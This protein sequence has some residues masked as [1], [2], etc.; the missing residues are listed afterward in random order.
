MHRLP[1]MSGDAPYRCAIDPR[2]VAASEEQMNAAV[3]RVVDEFIQLLRFG[4]EGVL[5]IVLA[6]LPELATARLSEDDPDFERR[7]VLQT[8]V[9]HRLIDAAEP[10]LR[11]SL[12]IA[13][14]EV[15]QRG[16]WLEGIVSR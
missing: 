6:A 13:L 15:I 3:E 12:G 11:R 4:G 7:S 10:L 8:F 2:T 16:D 5:P 14:R 1:R 9:E